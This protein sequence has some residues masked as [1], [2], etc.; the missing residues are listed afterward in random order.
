CNKLIQQG[1]KPALAPGDILEEL[2]LPGAA[3]PALAGSSSPGAPPRG[4]PPDLS[5]LQRSLWDAMAAEPKHVDVRVSS[6][7]AD[8]SA[9]VTETVLARAKRVGVRG[10]GQAVLAHH[11]HVVVSYPADVPLASCIRHSKSECSRRI[12]SSRRDAQRVQWCRGY[13]AGSVSRRDV[14]AA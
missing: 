9:L 3:E 8:T 7:G 12:N 4:Q 2:G 1:A 6:A 5:D 11:V 13:Y 10:L 14:A